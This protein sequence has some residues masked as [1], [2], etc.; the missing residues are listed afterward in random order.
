[1]IE[2]SS[3]FHQAKSHYAYCYDE[4]T[5]HIK[6]KTKK[7]NIK[8]IYLYG[9]DPFDYEIKNNT[10]QWVNQVFSMHKY[11]SSSIYDYWI[12]AI[13]PLHR[14]FSYLFQLISSNQTLLYTEKGFYA[15]N[16]NDDILK[17]TKKCF[18][19]PWMNKIDI[20]TYPTWIK[21]AIWYQIF[22]DRFCRDEH[23]L[24]DKKFLPWSSAPPTSNNFF[25]GNLQGIINKLDYLCDLGI[26]AIYL[27]P[28]F[29]SPSNHKY[30]TIDYFNIDPSFGTNKLFKEL[31][32]KCHQKNIKIM[33]DGV[34]NHVSWNHFAW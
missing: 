30:D 5:L 3:V 20:L 17:T 31:V 22:P 14:R 34:F 21:S 9:G 16:E 2:K 4:N 8:K 19:F 10:M 12:I 6:I 32:I 33:L 27:N 1:M 25:G 24:T 18:N 26:N 15:E 28:I 7:D 11:Q 13:S 29:K 23:Y